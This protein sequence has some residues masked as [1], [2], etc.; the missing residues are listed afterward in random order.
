MRGWAP[1]TETQPQ[2]NQWLKEAASGVGLSST[3]I[4]TPVVSCG[5]LA[6][7]LNGHKEG[8][9]YLKGSEIYFHCENG[10]SL[11]GAEVSTCLDDGTWSSPTPTCQPGEDAQSPCLGQPAAQPC[12]PPPHTLAPPVRCSCPPGGASPPPALSQPR[13]TVT[14]PTYSLSRT[15]PCC[16]VEHHF[17]R[18]GLGRR[19]HAPLRAAAPEEEQHVRPHP[20]G[21]SILPAGLRSVPLFSSP[22]QLPL[23]CL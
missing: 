13:A 8:T 23:G 10:Y 7:P 22:L 19:G 17:R 6:P 5:W 21:P 3:P 11:A 15:E 16:V 9:K 4:S 20:P 12:L 1:Y 18:P 2:P 14:S